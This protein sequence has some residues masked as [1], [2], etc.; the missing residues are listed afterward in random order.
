MS[1]MEVRPMVKKLPPGCLHGRVLKSLEVS[2]AEGRDEILEAGI[3]YLQEN[4]K[5]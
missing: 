1:G 2:L 3:K 5:K 4:V